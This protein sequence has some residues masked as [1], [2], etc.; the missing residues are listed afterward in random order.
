MVERLNTQLG[1]TNATLDQV[2][3]DL[4]PR[5]ILRVEHPDLPWRREA[6]RLLQERD[7]NGVIPAD[8]IPKALRQLDGLRARSVRLTVAG[9]P[10]ARRAASEPLGIV[11][12]PPTA[13]LDSNRWTS[14]GPGNIGGRLRSVVIHPTNPRIIWVGSAGGGIWRSDNEGMSF[15]P[16][17]DLMANL[18]VSCMV[19]DPTNPQIIYAGT[20]EG[21]YYTDPLRRGGGLFRTTDGTKWDRLSATIN[22]NFY[23]VNRLAISPNGE[24]LLAATR[25]GI[26]RSIDRDRLNW[27]QTL[28]GFMADV[29]FH[30]SDP[31]RAIA[32]GL[33]NGKAYYSTKGGEDWQEATHAGV[34]SGRV[35]VT[36]AVANPSIVYAS[37][38]VQGGQIWRSTDGGKTYSQKKSE[39][40]NIK[41]N[42]Y[43]PAYYLGQ[44]GYYDNVI[45]AGH[46]SDPNFV[47]VGGIDLWKSLDGGDRLTDISTWSNSNSAHADHRG[48]VS[49]PGFNA[50]TN[51]V[52]FFA[53]DG[54]LFK[55]D[56]V[57]T[58]GN[59][60]NP[61]RTNRWMRRVE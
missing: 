57:L 15:S 33:R 35:E 32:G 23:H 1:L 45:W 56:D 14:I 4:L 6:F 51:K 39:T 50:T 31:T 13:G 60:P 19:M 48:L 54:G 5:L 29:D 2:Q 43:G 10:S 12:M 58:L 30:P 11:L 25:E 9:L 36:Y 46:P 59:N 52:V 27:N 55:T 16:V 47:I 28:A 24:T 61:P 21:F 44:Q 20:G 8:A 34:W 3:Q 37:V 7:Q 40:L 53:N 42:T 38:D 26:F 22:S 18:S 49:H 17:D 41:T